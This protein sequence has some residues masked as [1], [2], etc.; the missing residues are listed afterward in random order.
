MSDI[1]CRS[2]DLAD[3]ARSPQAKCW[4]V[5]TWLYAESAMAW[6][7]N[8]VPLARRN[9]CL[10]LLKMSMDLRN[11]LY[12]SSCRCEYILWIP[13]KIYEST[14]SATN[15]LQVAVFLMIAHGFIICQAIAQNF[16]LELLVI[17]MLLARLANSDGLLLKSLVSPQRLQILPCSVFC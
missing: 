8:E 4:W 6:D 9:D 3:H 5:Q 10:W 12:M 13:R 16:H 15:R 2:G 7:M 17:I 14:S 1:C 11:C